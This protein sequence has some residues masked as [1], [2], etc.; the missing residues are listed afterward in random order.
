MCMDAVGGRRR[1]LPENIRQMVKGSVPQDAVRVLA[2]LLRPGH[3]PHPDI[4]SPVQLTRD[5]TVGEVLEVMQ[6]SDPDRLER[7]LYEEF[8]GVP[9]WWYDATRRPGAVDRPVCGNDA[10]CR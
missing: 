7:D 1:G 4:V 10:G 3:V 2:P 6:D 8:G 5:S 9:E